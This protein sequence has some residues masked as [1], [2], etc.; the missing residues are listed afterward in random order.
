MARKNNHTSVDTT[1]PPVDISISSTSNKTSPSDISSRLSLSALSPF[2]RM[3]SSPSLPTMNEEADSAPTMKTEDLVETKVI[4][5]EAVQALY[6]EENLLIV[7]N[8]KPPVFTGRIKS[9]IWKHVF[10]FDW[11]E[12]HHCIK[13]HQFDLLKYKGIAMISNALKNPKFKK[14]IASKTFAPVYR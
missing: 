8:K 13:L 4:V 1:T 2:E 7:L 3:A 6:K 10:H 12:M 11:E 5:T 9:S 14:D